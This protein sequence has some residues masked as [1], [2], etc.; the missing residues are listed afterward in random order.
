MRRIIY[1]IQDG[2]SVFSAN[3]NDIDIYFGGLLSVA[4]AEIPKSVFLFSDFHNHISVDITAETYEFE[5]EAGI[6]G[7]IIVKLYNS[8]VNLSRA[9]VFNTDIIREK[10]NDSEKCFVEDWRNKFREFEHDCKVQLYVGASNQFIN[11]RRIATNSVYGLSPYK[12]PIP[13][14][15]MMQV[16]AYVAND[17]LSCMEADSRRRNF[18]KFDINKAIYNDPATIVYWADGT[19]TV[20]KA[21]NGESYD[22][23]KGLAMCFAKK[24]RGNKGNYYEEFKKHLPEPEESESLG[25]VLVE[26]IADACN[27]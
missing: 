15:E 2:K 24:A 26:N 19:K 17:L 21:Q 13:S 7:R 22:P 23:E 12:L 20:V 1:K 11:S 25:D 3:I 4:I 10:C 6:N 16:G 8:K 18:M 9:M 14:K 5:F 27:N